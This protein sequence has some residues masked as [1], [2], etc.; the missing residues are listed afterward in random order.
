[1]TWSLQ[2][3]FASGNACGPCM[4]VDHPITADGL[5]IRCRVNGATRQDGN[6]T[7]MKYGFPEIVAHI[8]EY[9]PLRPGDMILSGTPAGTGM[10]RGPD[11]PFLADGDICEVEVTGT[12]VLRNRVVFP[13][14]E[15]AGKA[16]ATGSTA[17]GRLRAR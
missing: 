13:A 11:G 5:R 4:V 12:G 3:N 9:L 7:E 10:E 1:L 17:D 16:L 2:K 15:R 6:T 8:E 14:D